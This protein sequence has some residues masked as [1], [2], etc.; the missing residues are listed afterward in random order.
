MGFFDDDDDPF[1]GIVRNFFGGGAPLR[2]SRRE[3]VFIRGEEEDRNI[4]FVEDG[5]K[6]YLVFELPGFSEKDLLV[7]V[8][9]RSLEIIAQKKV[10][11]GIQEYLMEKLGQGI[12]IRKELPGFIN[13]KGFSYTMRNGILEVVFDKRR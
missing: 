2:K 9:N 11:E 3:N 5:N 6:F 10:G 7:T 8:K 1:E 4:D 13:P 12:S